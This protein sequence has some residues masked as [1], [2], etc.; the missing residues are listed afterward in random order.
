[1]DD[2]DQRS[3][4][5]HVEQPDPGS[6]SVCTQSDPELANAHLGSEMKLFQRG[7]AEREMSTV[8]KQHIFQEYKKHSA[9]LQRRT[10]IQH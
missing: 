1:M 5:F 6:P 4:V 3:L 9:D 2:T 10:R 8:R 7:L